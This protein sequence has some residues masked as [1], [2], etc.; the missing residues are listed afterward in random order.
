MEVWTCKFT[1]AVYVMGGYYTTD[2]GLSNVIEKYTISTDSW[3]TLSLTMPKAMHHSD[4][5]IY[6]AT[7]ECY[8][9][10]QLL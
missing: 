5:A 4:A 8:I 2:R 9:A 7:G 10:G 1:D 3:T 6:A